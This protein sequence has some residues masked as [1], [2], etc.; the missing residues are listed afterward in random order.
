M[1]KQT[2]SKKNANKN[3]QPYFNG[4]KAVRKAKELV[5]K[6]NDARFAPLFFQERDDLVVPMDIL[7]VSHNFHT[8]HPHPNATAHIVEDHFV[9]KP[10]MD[11]TKFDGLETVHILQKHENMHSNYEYP[12][13]AELPE[14]VFDELFDSVDKNSLKRDRQDKKRNMRQHDK[15]SDIPPKT[16]KIQN[17]KNKRT[18]THKI[19][20]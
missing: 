7:H 9:I 14:D 11:E 2:R 3:P 16:K 1:A 20:N 17:T 19:A 10:E 5:H 15:R 6:K 4:G 8:Y 13:Y 18:K 12:N